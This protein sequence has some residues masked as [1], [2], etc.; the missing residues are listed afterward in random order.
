MILKNLKSFIDLAK[1]KPKKKI[2]VAAAE[3]KPVLQAV[4]DAIKEGFV[5][6]VLIGDEEKS[7]VLQMKLVLICLK[8]Q[9]LMRNLPPILQNLP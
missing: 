6:A 1:T 9:L 7:E 4:S 5:D 3:D 8:L 2:S